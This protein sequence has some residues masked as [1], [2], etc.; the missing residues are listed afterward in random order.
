MPFCQLLLSITF[1]VIMKYFTAAKYLPRH[2]ILVNEECLLWQQI[3]LEQEK[4][5][6]YM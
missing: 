6:V 1:V 5:G 2:T 3:V 4:Y